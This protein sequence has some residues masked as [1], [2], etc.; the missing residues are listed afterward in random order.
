VTV[1][2]SGDVDRVRAATDIVSVVSK[3]VQLKRAGRNL[4]ACCPFH[5]EK[6]P[7][8]NVNPEKQIFKCFGCGAGGS[9]FDFVMRIEKLTFAEALRQM[10]KDAGIELSR[11]KGAAEPRHARDELTRVFDWAQRGF[12]ANLAHADGRECRQYVEKRGISEKEVARF[13]LGFSRPG[14]RN[15]LEE[16]ERRGVPLELL[17]ATGLVLK[18]R[19][20]RVYDAFRNR[21]MFPIRNAQG[22]IIGFGA[23]SL[24]G[25]EPKYLNSAES[26]TFRKRHTVYGL[27]LLGALKSGDPVLIMEGYTDVIMATQHGVRGAV[28]TLGTSLTADQV[29]LLRRYA[30]R[31]VLVYD[32][33]RAGSEASIRAIPL[34]LGGGIDLRVVV[35]PGGEDPCDF[36]MRRKEAG[37]EELLSHT[38]ELADFMIEKVTAKFELGTLDGKRRAA[39]FFAD[40]LVA[41][42]DPVVRDATLARA[43]AAIGVA[44]PAIAQ[45]L[46]TLQKRP[47][48]REQAAAAP[49][50][51]GP[52]APA[53]LARKKALRDVLDVCLN[54][55]ALI[56][57]RHV[58]RL[59]DLLPDEPEPV[60]ELLAAVSHRAWIDPEA[61]PG[62]IMSVVEDETFRRLLGDLIRDDEE[63]KD[64]RPQLEGAFEYLENGL[65]ER[66]IHT[67]ADTVMLTGSDDA[68]R[69]LSEAKLRAD[70]LRRRSGAEGGA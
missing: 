57:E 51:A 11:K 8:F 7:S 37:V 48:R 64:L 61:T 21:L 1:D 47:Q 67:L 18:N 36:F 24:D 19:E 68:L 33:D 58:K 30:D 45:L 66:E 26:D 14:W 15:L 28:A 29:R 9:V 56:E 54:A 44:A 10:A 46:E 70:A 55:P 16:G 13:G 38:K 39:V 6:T 41:I 22:A 34:L 53:S 17:L 59:P 20:G 35:L 65:L 62:A 5:D 27:E 40:L 50:H 52:R 23:R 60:R 25:S 2:S 43:A 4:K 32:G 12:V 63:P 31:A 3:F 49:A 69:L 42:E